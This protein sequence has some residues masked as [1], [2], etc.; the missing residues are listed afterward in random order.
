MDSEDG[1]NSAAGDEQARLEAAL[2]EV[3]RGTVA[4]AGTAVLLLMVGWF[5]VYLAI[6]LPRGS[7]G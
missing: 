6:F 2:G 1:T 3:P 4:V 7:V 5:L